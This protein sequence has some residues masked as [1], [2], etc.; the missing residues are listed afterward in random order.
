MYLQN[1]FDFVRMPTVGD[2]CWQCQCSDRASF[3]IEYTCEIKIAL[4]RFRK[5]FVKLKKKYLYTSTDRTFLNSDC[6]ASPGTKW[7]KQFGF[8]H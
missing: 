8:V 3:A 2:F 5:S 7:R 4:K 1:V 6:T